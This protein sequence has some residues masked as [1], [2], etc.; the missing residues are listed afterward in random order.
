MKAIALSMREIRK[1]N[2]K[3]K[4]VQ[5]EDLAKIYSTPRLRYQADFENHRRWLTWDILCGKVD[6][7]HPLWDYL[8]MSGAREAELEFFI[9]YPCPPDIIGVDYYATSER[10]LDEALERYP[11]QSHGANPF[12]CY[13]DVE[14]C[15]VP[16]G[17]PSGLGVLLKECWD[18][19]NIPMAV[20][21]AHINCDFDN[22]IRWF[23][24]IY[25][26]SE[27]LQNDGVDIRAV[28]AWAMLGAHGWDTLLTQGKGTYESGVFDVRSGIP[29]P[30]PLA[31]YIRSI[32]RDPEYRDKAESEKGWWLCEDRFLFH[33]GDL[34]VVDSRDERQSWGG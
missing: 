30:T 31:N 24:E 5:T 3:A 8:M 2:P 33:T 22:Q 14:A 11:Q 21:E 32:V 27:K 7:Y 6:C 9:E 25:H 16:H 19:Y 1:V 10:Y 23:S 18:R 26:T 13:A 29:V 28:T 34:E 12:E 20:T 17:Q 4:L 15:R